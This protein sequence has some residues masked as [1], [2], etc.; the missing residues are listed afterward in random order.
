MTNPL[1]AR[2]VVSENL[3]G[4]RAPSRKFAP[5]FVPVRWRMLMPARGTTRI[6]GL[7]QTFGAIF[8]GRGILDLQILAWF[9]STDAWS[10]YYYGAHRGVSASEPW[11]NWIRNIRTARDDV[12]T[13][14]CL[15]RFIDT[16]GLISER[17]REVNG[18]LILG[19]DT[20]I[21]GVSIPLN[22]YRAE[23]DPS[24]FVT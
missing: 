20:R 6:K 8:I 15:V 14:K 7:H 22:F 1:I 18:L 9:D 3:R 13:R 12:L 24:P 10:K 23:S 17:A 2:Y 19:A 4:M 11:R 5:D 16:A 21:T